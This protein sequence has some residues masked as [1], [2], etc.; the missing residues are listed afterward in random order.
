MMSV[1]RL[2]GITQESLKREIQLGRKIWKA[3]TKVVF[4]MANTRLLDF[5]EVS[6]IEIKLQGAP[7]LL[8]ISKQHHY[9][10][11]DFNS[12]LRIV[13]LGD[14]TCGNIRE[15]TYVNLEN[16]GHH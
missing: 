4:R 16:M 2:P 1:T 10:H 7:C 14:S 6:L 12:V 13:L 8:L 9:S 5:S 3:L 11:T 15:Y